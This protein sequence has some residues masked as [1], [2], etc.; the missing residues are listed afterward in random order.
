MPERR[1][2][3]VH[4]SSAVVRAHPDRIDEVKAAIARMPDVEVF[5]SEGGKIVVVLEGPDTKAV[6]A[7]LSRIALIDGVVTASLVFEQ[8]E[9]LQSL[10]D[11][12]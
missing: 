2:D 11:R 7:R 8:V 1:E 9:S 5:H 12:P 6:G 10:G 4:I 3:V